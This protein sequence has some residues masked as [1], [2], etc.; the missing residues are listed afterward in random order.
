MPQPL[1]VDT[2]NTRSSPSIPTLNRRAILIVSLLVLTAGTW[3][4]VAVLTLNYLYYYS[5]LSQLNVS[6]S[7]IS[8][9]SY[10]SNITITLGLAVS[11]P[12]SYVGL[13]VE[14]LSYTAVPNGS[15]T[16][17]LPVSA[18]PNGRGLLEANSNITVS[19]SVVLT[20]LG[21]TQFEQLCSQSQNSLSWYLSGVIGLDTRD[22]SLTPP[23]GSS[24]SSTC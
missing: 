11:N 5:A 9:Q 17:I 8:V 16:V 13:V 1:I 3:T 2:L 14:S 10:S 23:F 15:R 4:Y 21:M 24:A 6:I 22:G 12:T 7:S 19:S 18:G 20:G